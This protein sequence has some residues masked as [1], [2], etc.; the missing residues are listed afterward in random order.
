MVRGGG[1]SPETLVQPLPSGAGALDS[2]A[3]QTLIPG[4]FIVMEALHQPSSDPGLPLETPGPAAQHCWAVSSA[5]LVSSTVHSPPGTLVL[6]VHPAKPKGPHAPACGHRDGASRRGTPPHGDDATLTGMMP[7]SQGQCHHHRCGAT[8]SGTCLRCSECPPPQ[9][10]P[11]DLGRTDTAPPWAVGPSLTVGQQT[12]GCPPLP[13]TMAGRHRDGARG[14]HR[15]PSLAPHQ[16]GPQTEAPQGKSGC[17][18]GQRP[19]TRMD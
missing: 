1:S 5:H 12:L 19:H 3:W 17:L 6:L 2:E 14:D 16:L 4:W 7:P 15:R 18:G 8:P 13:T 11:L 9:H 10:S